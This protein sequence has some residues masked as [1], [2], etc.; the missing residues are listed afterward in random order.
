MDEI[1]RGEIWWAQL[2]EPRRSEAGFARP[3]LIVQADSFNRSRISTVLVAVITTNLRLAAAP[4]TVSLPAKLS[5]LPKDSV[6][7]LSLLYSLDKAVLTEYVAAIPARI[8]RS[9]DTALRTV[10]HL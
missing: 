6:I 5:G 2:P 7:N 8:Q 10:L 4:G 9:V 3:V 1:A